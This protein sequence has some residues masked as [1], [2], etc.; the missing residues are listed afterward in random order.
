MS[1]EFQVQIQIFSKMKL[2]LSSYD[3]EEF[4]IPK[5]IVSF[6][7]IL[8]ENRNALLISLKVNIYGFKYGINRELNECILLS[9]F[10]DR[11]LKDLNKFPIDV[12]VFIFND[13]TINSFKNM[14]NI[15]WACLYNNKD[16]AKLHR[17]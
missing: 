11:L 9:R 8:I 4:N 14:T 1:K 12:H 17:L 3:Y 10:D 5:E 2:Y 7:H 16:D 6:N 15:A 13:N